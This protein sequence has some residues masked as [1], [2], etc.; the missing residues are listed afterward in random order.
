MK[1]FLGIATLLATLMISG[2]NS[3]NIDKVKNGIM[4]FDK[5]ITVSQAFDNWKSCSNS[6]W[7]EFTTD[8]GKNIVEFTCDSN[9][10]ND[11]LPIFQTSSPKNYAAV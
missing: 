4:D 6:K 11:M 10:I 1:I 8:N 2:C 5:S 9:Q 3:S 7:S